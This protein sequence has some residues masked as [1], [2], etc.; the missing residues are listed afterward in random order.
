M[1]LI[2]GA[3]LFFKVIR[4]I[5]RSHGT[6]IIVLTQI[7]HFWTVTPVWIHWWLWNDAQSLKQHRG[8]SL[9]IFSC[10]QAAL[11]MVFSF[12][13][14]KDGLIE[15]VKSLTKNLLWKHYTIDSLNSSLK[16]CQRNITTKTQ[17][18]TR[19][20]QKNNDQHSRNFGTS[21]LLLI[22]PAGNLRMFL[23]IIGP[24]FWL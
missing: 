16:K 17:D 11:W 24:L 23:P 19:T 12:R 20:S 3:L 10:D 1:L 5:S 2:T 21:Y 9:F 13:L 15:R 4:Q 6:K 18:F 8:G 7:W 22:T 14:K